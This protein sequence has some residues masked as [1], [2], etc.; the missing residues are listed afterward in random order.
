MLVGHSMD[1]WKNHMPPGMCLRSSCD[2]HLDPM[3]EHT[4]L[5][6]LETKN[7]EPQDVEPIKLD[8]YLGYA[9]WFQKQ[10][11]ISPR[12]DWVKR[13]DRS[14]KVLT[15]TLLN[16]NV[17]EAEKIVLAV[18]LRYFKNIPDSYATMFPKDRFHHTAEFVDFTILANK[19]ALIVGGRQSAFEWAALIHEKGAAHVH[20]AYR[21]E[22]PAFERSEWD[23]ANP[24]LDSMVDNPAWFRNLDQEEKDRIVHR[25]WTEGRAKLEPWLAG[26]VI[27]PTIHLHPHTRV[28]RCRELPTK[29][30]MVILSD[31]TSV[32]VDHIILATGYKLDVERVPLLASGNLMNDL[33]TKNG[34]PVLDETFQSSIPNLYFT[35]YPAAQD[36]GPFFGFT[37]ATRASA[38][39]IGRAVEQRS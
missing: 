24:L 39:I 30:I 9:E 26:R 8:F 36:F 15:A 34:F 31:D 18:G 35:G 5:R 16:G 20:L 37:A 33:K 4:I 12:P 25:M 38:N 17:I 21:H 3:N 2:W 6:Y 14:D 23:W 22:T 1:Y 10:T 29:E 32:V 19:R 7:L 27:K 28:I 13:L 11:G